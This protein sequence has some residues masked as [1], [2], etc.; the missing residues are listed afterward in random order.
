[1][2]SQCLPL[3]SFGIYP[4]LKRLVVLACLLCTTGTAPASA[5][6]IDR[7]FLTA[8]ELTWINAHVGQLR[9]APEGNYP[10]FS[11]IES[12]AWRGLSA[13]MIR[14]LESRIGSK[15][16]ILPAQN[17][18]SILANVQQGN[19]EIITSIKETQERSKYLSFTQPYVSVPTAIIVK[20]DFSGG[21][22][23]STFVGKRVAVG[24]G[25]GV[26][27]F[28]EDNFPEVN[29]TLVPDDL[30]GMRKLSFGEVDAIIMDVAS[31]SFFIEREK[32][33]N[34]RIFEGFPY[35]Y[36]LSFAVSK[37][38]PIL[39]SILSKTLMSIPD[40]DRQAVLK[41]WISISP[42]PFLLIGKWIRRWLP[43]IVGIFVIL[44][45]IGA[46]TWRFQRQR[47]EI[48]QKA[49]R[50]ARSLIEASLDPMVTISVDGKITDVN[51]ATED[52]TGANRYS[53]IDSD[54]ADYFTDRGK[55][56]EVYQQV[57]AQG[58]VT[59]YPL[60]IR[61]TSGKVIDVLYN[62]SVYRD[63]HGNVLGVFAT[64]RDITEHKK[65]QEKLAAYS[66]RLEERS[67]ELEHAKEAA[68]AA[69]LAKSA[70]LA[71]MSH[72]IRTPMNA[73]LGMA[74]ILRRE[75]VTPIQASRLDKIDLASNHL[76]S[77]I[78]DILDI[79]KIEAGKF[80]IEEAPVSIVSL[81]SNVHSILSERAQ[82]KG[83]H[84]NTEE[85]NF[86]LNLQGDSTRVQQ[87]LLNYAT[88]AVKFTEKG[89]ISLRAILLEETD[90]SVQVRFE[91][92]D[93]GIGIP[94][95]T[96]PRL[97][98]AFEQA[99]NS[100]TRKYGGTGLG[101]AITRRLAGLMGG[102]V[103]VESTPGVG[104][105]FW[106]TVFLKKIDDL[107]GVVPSPSITNAD[108][109]RLIRERYSGTRILLVD[110]EPLNIYVSQTLCEE[111][112]LVVDVAED[113]LQAVQRARETFYALILMDM[114]MPNLN[115]VEA[116]RQIRELPGYRATPILAM[117]AN[118]FA[119]DEVLCF[120]AGM[121]EFIVKPIAPDKI[122]A[123]LLK[124]LEKGSVSVV[125][126]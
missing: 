20:A 96:M 46:V 25:Y 34:L 113:G 62:A 56:R 77:T 119:E 14:L 76:L 114:Q 75:G 54:F 10:P 109:E 82:A 73:I 80:I 15:F 69:N 55:A 70:F 57:F 65:S 58:A 118:A 3:N 45:L 24:K 103:G 17:L 121:S 13:D 27:K 72:E 5:E 63:D 87:A 83:L 104:S 125:L 47:R 71:N 110:D 106:F 52:V 59:D 42:P 67:V 108:A 4:W 29:L 123:T 92:Q 11:F 88:N 93:T 112:G 12:D 8:Q 66:R 23:P 28:L 19:A 30:D 97:F 33:T 35:T 44:I 95:E 81:L 38:L 43:L 2:T 100:T 36:E 115:G 85:G 49:A 18:D 68:E 9:V 7:N 1:M 91:V 22:W 124:W 84:L 126:E 86:P 78:N 61:H 79:S 50:Y 89:S 21:H 32:I 41:K 117:T 53:L 26:Q 101:L 39:H 102:E 31:A 98:S 60:A 37:D 16:Q 107:A 6:E 94:P 48:E 122:F 111:S 40:Q 105:T 99:D 64:A 74:N 90:K 120:E 51:R 116:T